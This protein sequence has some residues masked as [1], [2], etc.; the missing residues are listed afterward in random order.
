MTFPFKEVA[1]TTQSDAGLASG[2]VWKLIPCIMS[3]A[4][5]SKAACNS[6]PQVFKINKYPWI[7]NSPPYP[8]ISWLCIKLQPSCSWGMGGYVTSKMTSLMPFMP[9]YSKF[10]QA[11]RKSSQQIRGRFVITNCPPPLTIWDATPQ[12][13]LESMPY[14]SAWHLQFM[15]WWLGFLEGKFIREWVESPASY[16]KSY[17]TQQ[18]KHPHPPTLATLAATSASL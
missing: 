12:R 18:E 8:S 9:Y 17:R 5:D 4:E 2:T 16:S 3:L 13:P 6:A 10:K 7:H 1:M 14:P 11:L 15:F